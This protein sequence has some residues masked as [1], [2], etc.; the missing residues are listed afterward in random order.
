MWERGEGRGVQWGNVCGVGDR[1]TGRMRQNEG[2]RRWEEYEHTTKGTI[3][4]TS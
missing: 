2:R 3:R 4:L 1:V